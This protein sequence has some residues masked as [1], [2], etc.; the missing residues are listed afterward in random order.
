VPR[1][2]LLRGLAAAQTGGALPPKLRLKKEALAARAAATAAEAPPVGGAV[3]G[4]APPLRLFSASTGDKEARFPLLAA[5]P[6]PLLQ[7]ALAETTGSKLA[8]SPAWPPRMHA[9]IKV[10]VYSGGPTPG[11]PSGPPGGLPDKTAPRR[12]WRSAV[13]THVDSGTGLVDLLMKKKPRTPLLAVDLRRPEDSETHPNRLDWRYSGW[14]PLEP[15]SDARQLIMAPAAA[16]G[17]QAAA[18]AAAAALRAVKPV[19]SRP[20]SESQLLAFI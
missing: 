4:A 16:V 15:P 12:T 20:L 7:P 8:P 17:G 5:P 10:R 18:A 1:V 11:P 9:E 6:G 3:S 13:V 19:S 14:Q 2:L